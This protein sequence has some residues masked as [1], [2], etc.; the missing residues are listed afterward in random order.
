MIEGIRIGYKVEGDKLKVVLE[1]DRNYPHAQTDIEGVV[2]KQLSSRLKKV[3]SDYGNHLFV[4]DATVAHTYEGKP[5]QLQE[6][7][8]KYN[9]FGIEIQQ[10]ETG[11]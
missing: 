3:S 10:L 2:R 11:L 9:E 6:L 5:A 4:E 1:A 7:I 8:D